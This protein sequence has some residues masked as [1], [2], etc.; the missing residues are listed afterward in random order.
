MGYPNALCVCIILMPWVNELS[1]F[2]QTRK[3]CVGVS[4]IQD[5]FLSQLI[6]VGLEKFITFPILIY[7][8]LHPSDSIDLGMHFKEVMRKLMD[9]MNSTVCIGGRIPKID[10][11]IVL[12]NIFFQKFPLSSC[13]NWIHFDS[14]K[15][16]LSWF[17]QR[18]IFG[19]SICNISQ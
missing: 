2:I 6:Y 19:I 3:C 4:L 12:S 18:N 8:F 13:F 16:I 11:E 7:K 1:F 5:F 14:S 10:F 17:I 15:I 9:P